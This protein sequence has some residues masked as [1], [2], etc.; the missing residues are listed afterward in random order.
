MSNLNRSER[1]KLEKLFD[2][3]SGYVLNF[4]DRTFRDFFDEY[5]VEIDA[6][7]YKAKGTSKANRMR[8]FWDIADNH[9]AGRVIEG[10]ID[11]ATD[12]QCFADVNPLPPLIDSCMKIAKQLLNSQPVAEQS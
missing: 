10:L 4:S 2:M 11:Y 6:E 5:R 12:E 1:R 7:Q 9:I 3:E 8:T